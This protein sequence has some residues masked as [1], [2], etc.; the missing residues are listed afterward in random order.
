M[1]KEIG[2]S[3]YGSVVRGMGDKRKFDNKTGQTHR[4][5]AHFLTNPLIASWLTAF[6]RSIIGEC[7]HNIQK[8]GG[9]VAVRGLL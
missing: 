5:N 8:L 3:I 9:K 4:L 2:N 6:I 7:L 1:Y